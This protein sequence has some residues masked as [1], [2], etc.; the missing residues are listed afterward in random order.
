MEGVIDFV[1]ELND[2]IRVMNDYSSA[3]YRHSINVSRIAN[4]V[5]YHL[6]LQGKEVSVISNAA[7][8]HDIGKVK[9]SKKILFKSGKLT[10]RE[11]EI[12]KEHPKYGVSM[13]ESYSWAKELLVLVKNHHERWDGQGYYGISGKDI[14]LG[15]RIIGIADA[16]NAMTS[17]RPYQ[18]VMTR[19]E[20]LNEL[21]RCAGIQFDPTLTKMVIRLKDEILDYEELDGI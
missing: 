7:L 10:L 11:W 9:I 15:A 20:S 3:I 12:I 21:E 4:R 19:K 8:L 13:L 17:L 16:L 14:P 18:E 2:L 1:K 5:A 6:G